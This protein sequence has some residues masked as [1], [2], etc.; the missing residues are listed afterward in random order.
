[1]TID[2]SQ[3]RILILAPH[4]DDET[5]GC[6]GLMSKA[7]AAGAEVYVQFMTVGDTADSSPKGVSTA[8]ERY[9][10]IKRVAEFYR[11]DGWEVAFPGD[12][13]HLKLDR[14]PR[15]QLANMIERHSALSIA[16]LRPTTL[17][18]PHR[19]SYN[20]DHQVTAEAAHTALRP[21]NAALRHHPALVLAYEEAADQWRLEPAPA[22][23]LLV[24]LAESHVDDKVAAMRLYGTQIHDHPHTRSELTLRSLAALRGM[25]GGFSFAEGFH[26][27]RWSA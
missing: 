19:T 11:W 16:E 12:E 17:I 8:A 10:E 18:A 25:Q 9:G 20:Q 3:Q 14:L 23:N 21:S 15:F 5:L 13:F 27:L 22:P 1:M 26:V 24:R 2:W 4:P 6:G 7:K